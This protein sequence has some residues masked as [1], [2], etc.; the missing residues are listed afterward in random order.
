MENLVQTFNDLIIQRLAALDLKVF[1]AETKFGLP[2]DAIRNVLRSEKQSGP[3]LTR[4]KEICDALG[5][6]ITISERSKIPGFADG[7]TA[8]D[9]GRVEALRAGYLPIPWHREAG[10]KGSSPIAFSRAWM[11][12]NNLMPDPLA[13]IVPDFVHLETKLSPDAVLVIDQ[14]AKKKPGYAP[15]VVMLDGKSHLASVQFEPRAI[16]LH[17]FREDGSA[18][19]LVDE[20]RA[21][22]RP[23]GRAIWH[24][25]SFS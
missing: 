6:S 5:L 20:D 16:V 4:A 19:L 1:A 25:Q 18:L 22:A 8:T 10:R 21:A 3:T 11:D 15:W 17:R 9:F 14:H 7:D 24:G 2:P 13:A 12:A 23:L